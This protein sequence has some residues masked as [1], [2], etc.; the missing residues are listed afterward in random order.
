MKHIKSLVLAV[1]IIMIALLTSCKSLPKTA[2]YIHSYPSPTGEYI[3]DIY[4]EPGNATVDY[5][6]YG[7]IRNEGSKGKIIYKQYH[8]EESDVYWVDEETVSI[9][10][11]Q[12]KIHGKI[13]ESYEYPEE[14]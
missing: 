9:N 11:I 3:L 7:I 13:Y 2:K 4:F 10:D 5:T 1:K 6:T 14:N 12:I 8:L